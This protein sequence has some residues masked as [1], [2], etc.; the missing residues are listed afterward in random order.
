MAFYDEEDRFYELYVS[1][2]MPRAREDLVSQLMSGAKVSG[3]TME[4]VLD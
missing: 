4:D 2:L 1:P 3:H